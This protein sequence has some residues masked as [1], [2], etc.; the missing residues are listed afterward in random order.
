MAEEVAPDVIVGETVGAKLADHLHRQGRLQGGVRM[1]I[2]SLNKAVSRKWGIAAD[3]FTD[4]AG[5]GWI[6]DISEYFD[7]EMLYAIVRSEHGNRSVVAVV[8]EDEIGEFK[9][10]GQWSSPEARAG[11]LSDVVEALGESVGAEVRQLP[12]PHA[13][14][15]RSPQPNPEDPRL[16][17][18]WEGPTQEDSEIRSK[19][20]APHAMHTTYGEA[21]GEV[22]ELLMRGC[23]VEVWSGVKHPELK[24]DI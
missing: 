4:S 14:P 10:T 17:V 9:K 2:D 13:T 8:D 11:G 20:E 6:I 22:M 7:N 15:R 3:Q 5:P 19:G 16:I 18:W 1:V 12:V 24:V 21:Q 23:K